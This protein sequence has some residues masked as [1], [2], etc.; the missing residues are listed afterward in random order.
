MATVPGGP[1]GPLGAAIGAVVRAPVPAFMEAC[2]RLL[3]AVVQRVRDLQAT[4]LD[5]GP[6]IAV[7][8]EHAWR[9][10]HEAVAHAYLGELNRYLRESGV[11]VPILSANDLWQTVEGEIETW[12]GSGRML[13]DLRQLGA[14][15]A[16]QPRIVSSLRVSAR[17]VWGQA[18][19]GR[20]GVQGQDLSAH[21]RRLERTLAEV[22]AAVAQYNI[23]PFYGG[24]LGGFMAGRLGEGSGGYVCSCGDP[25]APLDE[26]GEPRA[27]LEAVRRVSMFASRFGRVLAHLDPK[28][29]QV[30]LLPSALYEARGHAPAPAARKGKHAGGKPARGGS[31]LG[32]GV[33]AGAGGAAAG[34]GDEVGGGGH[35]V[36]WVPGSQGS[37]AFVFGHGARSAG[38]GPGAEVPAQL[39]TP[40]GAA[41][42]VW[43]GEHSVT[44]ALFDVRLAGR[45]V[46]DYCTLAA[47]ALVGRALVVSGPAGTVGRLSING[48]PLEIEVP[49]E[50]PQVI[51]HEEIAVVVAAQGHLGRIQ[52]GDEA[53]FIGAVGLHRDGRPVV[54]SPQGV[55]TRV[56]ADA[57]V[58]ELTIKPYAPVVVAPKPAPAPPPQRGRGS[59]GGSKGSKKAASPL[60]PPPAPPPPPPALAGVIV[61]PRK[62]PPAPA[63]TGWRHASQRGHTEGTSAR[64]ASIARPEDLASLGAPYG[65]GWYRARLRGAG[66]ALVAWPDSGDRVQLFVDGHPG[67][68]LGSGAGAA[69]TDTL[70]LTKRE[71]TLVTLAEN[72]GRSA[73][74]QHM[75]E[76]RGVFGD[77]WQVRPVKVPK[78]A[79]RKGATIEPMATR[80]PLFGVH[81]GQVTAPERLAW[82][83][84]GKK[85]SPVLIRPRL[86]ESLRGVLLVGEEPLGWVDSA[87]PGWVW[88][89]AE[90]WNRAGGLVQLATLGDRDESVAGS[91]GLVEVYETLG[92]VTEHAEWAFARW[93]MPRPDEFA[94]AA[95]RSEGPVWHRAGFVPAAAAPLRLRLAGLSKGQAYIDEHH[96]GRYFVATASGEPVGPGEGLIIPAGR[97]RAGHEHTVTIFDEHGKSPGKV[98]LEAVR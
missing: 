30:S 77:L 69:T 68:L 12:T 5:P 81:Q 76:R 45:S 51:E 31:P 75:T 56:G 43:L 22:L 97:L 59:R 71:H 91:E 64:Y 95:V 85:R 67:P 25:G 86:S 39:L 98:A 24:P 7:Q 88:V 37:V 4:E 34:A 65:Y 26:T 2:S 13:A 83:I 82:S 47:F 87:G 74:G 53:V 90:R 9:C 94:S 54:D 28:R 35:A 41:L 66:K 78:T 27:G 3:G 19:A 73:G 40:E 11:E 55:V 84:G 20:P 36:V 42:E 21:P 70:A 50:H 32:P 1:A 60:P 8:N 15:H 58:A 61:A 92:A 96:L 44:W 46:L 23:E 10:G 63:L 62:A 80:A 72:L 93:E 49:S 16:L 29:Q 52:V 89:D 33:G 18:A 38:D 79:L 14:V 17:P 48:S 57:S 6:I